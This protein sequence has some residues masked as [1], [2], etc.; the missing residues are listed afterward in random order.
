MGLAGASFRS[1]T[2]CSLNSDYLGLQ[3]HHKE[4]GNSHHGQP[5]SLDQYAFF[6]RMYLMLSVRS[7]HAHYRR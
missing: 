7:T 4:A 1:H 2:G 5:G 6:S 3:L